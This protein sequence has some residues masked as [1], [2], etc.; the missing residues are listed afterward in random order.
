[1]EPLVAVSMRI[2]TR[3]STMALAQ[4]EEIARRLQA[5]APE[6]GVEI[7]KFETVG[8]YRPDQQVADAWRQGRR[9][10]C[11]NSRR[12]KGRPTAPRDA[13]AQGHAGQ[14]GH[15]GAGDRGDARAR[16]ARPTRWCCAPAF[17][18]R[19]SGVPAA[20]V[21]GSAPMRCAVPPMRGGCFRKSRSFIF[22][23]PPTPAC[24]SSTT[25]ELQR[26]PG[27][28]EVGPADALIM[29]RSGLERVGLA[30]PHRP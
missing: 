20:R 13:F 25:R 17:H 14:R 22:A 15:A 29:A 1:M 6:L 8:P 16:S 19:R 9:L 28:G 5:A 27:G 7:V 3:K 24:A 12:R 4:T 26:L 30:E 18:S 10:R 11:G 21:F 2:G 23:A